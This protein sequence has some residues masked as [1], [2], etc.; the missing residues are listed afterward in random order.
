MPDK[1]FPVVSFFLSAVWRVYSTLLWTARFLLRNWQKAF[2]SFL[3][4]WQISFL[5][6]SKI[7]P[8]V[9]NFW[10]FDY[11]VSQR[12]YI[13]FYFVY[14]Y[15]CFIYLDIHISSQI[16]IIFGHD[17][18]KFSALLKILPFFLVPSMRILGH[19]MMF[20]I[21]HR[22]SSLFHILFPFYYFC[23]LH[24]FCFSY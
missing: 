11:S 16:S 19:M 9:F 7:L 21:S 6:A 20:H 8:L 13:W 18:I 2:W 22:L 10:H 4:I 23:L 3:Y 1:V 15:L 5:D 17:F 14:K 24:F 12:G